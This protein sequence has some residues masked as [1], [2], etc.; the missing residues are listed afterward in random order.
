MPQDQ[1]K[2]IVVGVDGSEPSERALRWA[3][4]YAE[5][6]G[7]RVEA[8]HAWQVPRVYGAAVAALPGEAFTT[9]AERT[10][11]EAIDNALGDD[12]DIDSVLEEGAAPKVLIKRSEGAEL[13]V[14]GSRGHGGFVGT[15]IGSVSLHCVAH[16]ACPVVVIRADEDD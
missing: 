8:V 13:L 4:E 11:R 9:W 15:L 10:L 3:K 5:L 6:T 14:I 2:R 16:A 7:G 12:D 1:V